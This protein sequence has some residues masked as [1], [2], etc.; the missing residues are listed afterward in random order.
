MEIVC[1]ACGKG[2]DVPL[3]CHHCGALRSFREA[4]RLDKFTLFGLPAGYS[5]DKRQL[6]AAY[7]R[8]SRHLH[9]DR[10]AGS[11]KDSATARRLS[12][13]V[14]DAYQ[15]LRDPLKR[16]RYLILK[17]GRDPAGQ[18]TPEFLGLQLDYRER[19][20]AVGGNELAAL[21]E[22][23]AGRYDAALRLL[24]E[25]LE[26]AEPG[27]ANAYEQAAARYVELT[28]WKNLLAQAREKKMHA[29]TPKVEP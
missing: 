12:A 14:N 8:V 22:E 25:G 4:E 26:A 11:D 3:Y 15:I 16:A 21:V 2:G 28:Y 9:P 10:F 23:V 29:N 24:R 20:E 5:L 13:L 18:A 19:L 17:S 7:L 27:A 6:E 1:R